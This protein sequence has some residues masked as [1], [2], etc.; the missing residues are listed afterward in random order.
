MKNFNRLPRPGAWTRRKDDFLEVLGALAHKLSQPLTSLQ[1]TAEVALMGEM[2]VKECRR[3]LEISLQ[4]TQRMAETLET[5]RDIVEMERAGIQIQPI[6]WTAVIEEA[7]EA[8]SYAETVDRPRL[9]NEVG[10]EVWVNTSPQR[11]TLATGRL[12]GGAVRAN[13]DGRAV[14]IV[15]SAVKETASLKVFEECTPV[16]D[17]GVNGPGTPGASAKPV[18][19]KLER[20]VL[21]RSVECQG[22]RLSVTQISQTSRCYR[23]DLSLAPPAVPRTG[24]P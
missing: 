2:D 14:R 3:I 16:G 5:L 15:L 12:I 6:S 19:D 7:L 4:E 21:N 23:I 8:A 17:Q 1:G 13:R 10:G 20:W 24:R 22:G 9:V 18:L 11:L